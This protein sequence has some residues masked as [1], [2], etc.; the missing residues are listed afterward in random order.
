MPR[1]VMELYKDLSEYAKDKPKA[2]IY[3]K[4]NDNLNSGRMTRDEY[5]NHLEFSGQRIKLKQFLVK[6]LKEKWNSTVNTK[7][8]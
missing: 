3:E 7:N 4:I 8:Q 2:E 1:L 5:V 6:E